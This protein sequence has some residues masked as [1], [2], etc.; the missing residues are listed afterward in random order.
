VTISRKRP[1]LIVMVKEPLPGRVK[2]RLGRDIG[3]IPATWWFRHQTRRLIRRLS[4][5]RWNLMIAVSPDYQG[6]ISRFWPKGIGRIGQ[7]T[8][9]LRARMAYILAA[10]HRGPVCIIGGDIPGVQPQH[11]A[12]AFRT[13]GQNEFVFGPATDGGFWLVGAK[14]VKAIPPRLF[15]G[16]EWSTPQTL[17]D[18]VRS[19]GEV[20]VGFADRLSD[21]DTK[22]D[23]S[24]MR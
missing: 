5:P 7:G 10:P 23:L 17:D 13:L 8:G 16:I 18:T 11:I 6:L 4:D 19:L 22:N 3:V 1:T 21:V 12:T 9:D 20:R 14:R 24:P 15:E 2:T